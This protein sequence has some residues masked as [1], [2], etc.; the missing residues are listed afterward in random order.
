MCF[1]VSDLLT[2]TPDGKKPIVLTSTGF[3]WWNYIISPVKPV[4][5]YLTSTTRW[6]LEPKANFCLNTE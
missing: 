2:W 6:R 5:D 4:G 3:S 1:S